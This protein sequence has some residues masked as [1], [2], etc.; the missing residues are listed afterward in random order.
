MPY[1]LATPHRAA[2]TILTVGYRSLSSS[3]TGNRTGNFGIFKCHWLERLWAR[4]HP[5]KNYRPFVRSPA[6]G[7]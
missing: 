3:Q 7:Q 1:H 2:L 6:T 4:P 5:V